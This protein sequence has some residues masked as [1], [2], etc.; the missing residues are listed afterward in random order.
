MKNHIVVLILIVAMGGVVAASFA[1]V[2][3]VQVIVHAERPETLI[4]KTELSRLFLKRTTRWADGSKVVPFDQ[5]K[6]SPLRDSFLQGVHDMDENRYAK[7]WVKL[8]F[9]G[10]A[11]PPDT[12]ASDAS[13][14]AAVAADRAAIGYVAKGTSLPSGVKALKVGP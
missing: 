8:V 12:L 11:K 4:S 3:D 1:A 14:L 5:E 10:R 6:G 9:S 13:V 2:N 7:Y